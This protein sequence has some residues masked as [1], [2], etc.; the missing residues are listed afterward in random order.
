MLG[1]PEKKF[2]GGQLRPPRGK[3]RYWHEPDLES[4]GGDG[5]ARPRR[6]RLLL[7]RRWHRPAQPQVH[8]RGRS[9]HRR[10]QGRGPL[11]HRL[12]HRHRREPLRAHVV[13]TGN[14]TLNVKV[15][16]VGGI[17][18]SFS[19]ASGAFELRPGHRRLLEV[20]MQPSTEGNFEALVVFTTNEREPEKRVRLIG[21]SAQSQLV[22]NPTRLDLGYVVVGESRTGSFSCTNH[23]TSPPPSPSATSRTVM[24]PSS[25]PRSSETVNRPRS[26]PAVP[27]RSRSPSAPTTSPASPPPPSPSSTPARTPSRAFTSPPP[28]S[29]M[30]S[31]S[32]TR[33]RTASA[34]PSPPASASRKPISRRRRSATSGSATSAASPSPSPRSD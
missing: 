8:P 16:D 4:A 22:C 32:S 28:R 20:A 18:A 26:S 17:P 19:L 25:R 13:N 15:Q 12:R 14:A 24:P 21:R 31:R 33:T 6:P 30:H 11:R 7:R 2:G 23:L 9:G 5:C 27:S 29:T 34:S 1:P 3:R 10:P